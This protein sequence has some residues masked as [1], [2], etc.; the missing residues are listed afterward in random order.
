MSRANKLIHSAALL[1]A[2]ILLSVSSSS[3]AADAVQAR[4]DLKAMGIEYNEQEFAKAAGN[5]DMPAVQLF[6]D[7]GMD[8][9]SGGG[10]AIGLASGRG[11]TKMVQF[12]LSN[13]A[14][15]TSKALEYAH[16]RGHPD[17][18]KI[19]RDAGAKD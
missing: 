16:T 12:L 14:K 6:L 19:L 1:F 15:P 7:A 4:K 8:I 9:N 2:A 10:A 18:E 13:G 11:K 17:I 5:D 3:I